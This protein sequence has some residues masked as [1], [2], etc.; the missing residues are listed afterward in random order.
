ME[1]HETWRHVVWQ[2][3]SSM[4]YWMESQGNLLSIK[5][6]IL[7]FH[8]IPWNLLPLIWRRQIPWNSM[9]Y[10]MELHG[11]LVSFEMAIS[12]FHGI[13]LN[14]VTFDLAAADFH[15]I[16]HG[17]PWNSAVIWNGATLVPWNSME[18]LLCSIWR[19][20]NSMDFYI[21]L[22]G[23]PVN[24]DVI[25]IN[26]HQVLWHSMRLGDIWLG[27]SRVPL[28]IQRKLKGTRCQLKW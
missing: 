24:P 26:N 18:L 17:I 16:L 8:L 14:F 22:P 3:K 1:Y 2:L 25:W 23:S 12:K 19:L 13:P 11:T 21:K 9:E 5:V 7:T 15:G 20:Q 4:K 6:I 10:S 28:N 27:N